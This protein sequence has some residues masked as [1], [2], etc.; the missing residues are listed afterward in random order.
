MTSKWARWRLKSTASRLFSQT[1]IK[2]AYQRKHKSSA[3]LAFV[4]GIHRWPVDSHHKGPVTRKM[5]PFDDVI[6]I[7]RG[8]WST[9][10]NSVPTLHINMFVMYHHGSC[11][12]I[13]YRQSDKTIVSNLSQCWYLLCRHMRQIPGL[14]KENWAS[15]QKTTAMHR[16][17]IYVCA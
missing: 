17:G 13:Y 9:I 6:M 5:F 1:F 16:Y 15:K 8:P 4:R 11:H 7:K 2:C 12:L 3:S 14:D 10:C